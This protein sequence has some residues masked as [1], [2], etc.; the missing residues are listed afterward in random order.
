LRQLLPN[1]R[2]LRKWWQQLDSNKYRNEKNGR[3]PNDRGN[4]I[5]S[6]GRKSHVQNGAAVT[7]VHAFVL[8]KKAFI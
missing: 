7:P 3:H 6:P 1:S 5:F 2:I 4:P 8:I